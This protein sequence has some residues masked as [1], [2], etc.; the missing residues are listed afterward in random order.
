MQFNFKTKFGNNVYTA[1]EIVNGDFL[2]FKRDESSSTGV[3]WNKDD[4]NYN[5]NGGYWKKV[6]EKKQPYF[7]IKEGSIESAAR[8]IVANNSYMQNRS[9][10]YMI[11][12]IKRVIKETVDKIKNGEE[13][14]YCGTAGYVVMIQ[15]EDENYY[16]IEV[17]V[18][19]S[20]SQ[21]REFVNVEEVI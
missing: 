4:V 8:F 12:S 13:A 15:Q 6:E 11:G 18:D 7:S 17:L 19:P 14:W 1:L 9:V 10:D 20:V 21:D 16:V 5:I 3:Y 2:I